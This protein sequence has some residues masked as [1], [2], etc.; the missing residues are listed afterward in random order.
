MMMIN[1]LEDLWNAADDGASVPTDPRAYQSEV[2]IEQLMQAWC[3][4]RSRS[5]EAEMV[6][7]QSRRLLRQIMAG[8][9]MSAVD[10][11]RVLSLI[12]SIDRTLRHSRADET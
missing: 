8:G 2:E 3:L 7:G 11:S 4:E 9:S 10:R 1:R 6:L 5:I 12:R